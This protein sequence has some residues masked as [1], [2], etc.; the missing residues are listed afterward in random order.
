MSAEEVTL[1]GSKRI[2]FL[3]GVALALPIALMLT[4][5]GGSSHAPSQATSKQA[6][7]SVVLPGSHSD[8]A[9]G[10]AVAYV[11]G[12]PIGKRSYKHWLTIERALG[13]GSDAAHWALGFLITYSWVAGEAADRHVAVSQA[14]A[15]ARLRQD[16][17]KSFPK[18]GALQRYLAQSHQS[19][20][21]LLERVQSELLQSGIAAQVTAS[22]SSQSA[23][24][25]ALAG[26][27]QHFHAHWKSLT[28]C[29]SEYVM[30]DCKQYSGGAERSPG[31]AS[32]RGSRSAPQRTPTRSRASANSSPGE[33][34]SPPSG[35]SIESEAFPLNG[36]IPAT[37]T[38]DGKGISPP[39][40]W[41]H[42]PAQAAEL[43]LFVIDE[44]AAGSSGGIR[45]V[46][47]GI[48]PKS[49]G[50]SAGSVPAGGVVGVNAA[51]NAA[52][53]P[54][55]PAPGH[56]DTIEFVLYA[57][58]RQIPLSQGFEPALAEQ[59][60]GASK[61]LLGSAAVTYALYRRP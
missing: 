28:S 18:P 39:L 23:R 57:L 55:C 14:Q 25:A 56:M 22:S 41:A 58:K 31:P 43:V 10:E 36:T 40:K 54:I 44:S 50:V 61:D 7:S 47:G 33:V 26:F 9:A 6:G 32:P 8:L 13:A 2:G 52:Y 48:D 19:E 49:E 35:F 46:L 4:G 59:E 38:C 15:S 45:W 1:M 24:K 29:K 11:S 37:Y 17:L 16:E 12:T 60:Y 51:G 21:D 20:A 30:E 34:Y 53:G 27:E 3:L 42:V 5:C